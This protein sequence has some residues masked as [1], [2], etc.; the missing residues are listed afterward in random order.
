MSCKEVMDFDG[1]V[2][3][4]QENLPPVLQSS[5]P[6]RPCLR[7]ARGLINARYQNLRLVLYRPRL[8]T[9]TLLRASSHSNLSSEEQ[10]LVKTCRSIA[11]EI[12]GSVQ[13]DW[14][15][16]Q[17][18]VRNSIWFMFNACMVPMLSLLS[19]PSHIDAEIW[20]MDVET[21]LS[22]CDEMSSWSPVIERTREVIHAIYTISNK[23]K[24][25]EPLSGLESDCS[26]TWRPWNEDI[27]WNDVGLELLL[28]PSNLEFDPSSFSQ[29]T[30]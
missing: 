13:K 17:Q 26:S 27:F 14:F 6:C 3:K 10:A 8:L 7:M 15:P 1:H 18:V 29:N 12:I 25:T 9:T 11:S 5:Q 28:G 22:L 24:A 23:S 16:V 4:W 2:V 20:R 21:S 19:D 30:Y